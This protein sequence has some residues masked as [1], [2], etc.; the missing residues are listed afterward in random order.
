MLADF[1]TKP[2]SVQKFGAS[3]KLIGLVHLPELTS[4]ETGL[5]GEY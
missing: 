4:K 1:L 3:V 5:E 2:T